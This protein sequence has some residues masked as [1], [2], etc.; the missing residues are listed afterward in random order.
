MASE[1]IDP[2][3]REALDTMHA[4]FKATTAAAKLAKAV[5]ADAFP[6]GWQWVEPPEG[7]DEHPAIAALPDFEEAASTLRN[8]L[9]RGA[10]TSGRPTS[11][12]PP[13]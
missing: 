12:P 5:F 3:L 8:L 1:G 10:P 11:K 9:E 7:F 2:A 6:G 4:A 13:K